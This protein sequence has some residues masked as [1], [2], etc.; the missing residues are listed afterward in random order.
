[1]NARRQR[2]KAGPRTGNANED[3]EVARR[4]LTWTRRGAILTGLGI[5]VA[6]VIAV[7]SILITSHQGTASPQSSASLLTGSVVCESGRPVVG[8]WIAAST[9]QIDSGFAHLGPADPSGISYPVG[10]TATYSYLLPHSGTYAVHVGCGGQ[11][12]AWDSSNYSPLLSG[13]KADLRCDDPT[14]APMHGTTPRG[15]C[16]ALR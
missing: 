7:A 14:T 12:N 1:M 13:T 2:A 9:G 10:S 6:S 4:S 5:L 11:A 8:V 3:R 16:T 15:T